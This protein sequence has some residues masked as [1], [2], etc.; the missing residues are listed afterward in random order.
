MCSLRETQECV[1]SWSMS[2]ISEDNEN[3]MEFGE[4]IGE[5]ETDSGRSEMVSRETLLSK[6]RGVNLRDKE[7]ESEGE[8]S[9][10]DI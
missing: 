6:V 1:V 10:G 7:D 3:L 4:F 5:L 9:P 8:Y 2:P